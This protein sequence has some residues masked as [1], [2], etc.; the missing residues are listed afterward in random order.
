MYNKPTKNENVL[1]T[2]YKTIHTLK[3]NAL[4]VATTLVIMYIS[5]IVAQITS[6]FKLF[7]DQIAALSNRENPIQLVNMLKI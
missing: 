7:V 4:N 6:H 3:S 5:G 1:S 2:N